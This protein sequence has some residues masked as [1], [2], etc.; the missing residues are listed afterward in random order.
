M[1]LP[2]EDLSR[3]NAPPEYTCTD[4]SEYDGDTFDEEPTEQEPTTITP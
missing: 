4:R 1:I 3:F 2:D